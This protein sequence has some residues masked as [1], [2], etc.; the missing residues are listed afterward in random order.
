M[1]LPLLHGYLLWLG[2]FVT[3]Q[4]A[5]W[6]LA[7]NSRIKSP[8]AD[9]QTTTTNISNIFEDSITFRNNAR[10]FIKNTFRSA[11]NWTRYEVLTLL[12]YNAVPNLIFL[13]TS[14]CFQLEVY[15]WQGMH[16]KVSHS[17]CYTFGYSINWQGRSYTIDY[18]LKTQ[19]SMGTQASYMHIK[20]IQTCHLW[21][22]SLVML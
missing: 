15:I 12:L 3:W 7:Q 20:G 16:S 2:L 13:L 17:R 1:R 21:N 8:F 5:S 4:S 6:I 10:I 14:E 22:P 19:L 11:G 18:G 9:L